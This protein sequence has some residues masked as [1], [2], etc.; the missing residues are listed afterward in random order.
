MRG[1]AAF[2][3]LLFFKS[4]QLKVLETR[5]L[6][7]SANCTS[8]LVVCFESFQNPLK[9]FFNFFQEHLKSFDDEVNA[10]LDN[11]FGPRGK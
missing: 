2:T 9:S 5:T 10:F 7:D 4:L 6:G 8:L 1:G 11:M 3:D